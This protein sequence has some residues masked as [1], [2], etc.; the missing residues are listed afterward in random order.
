MSRKKNSNRE[1][2][3][4]DKTI[5]I[6]DVLMTSYLEREGRERE[7]ERESRTRRDNYIK[8]NYI[9]IDMFDSFT[10]DEMQKCLLKY[11]T[12]FIF[13]ALLSG[14]VYKAMQDGKAQTENMYYY[15]LI[16]TV[17]FF[18][19]YYYALLDKSMASVGM[20]FSIALIVVIISTVIYFYSSMSYESM[21]TVAYFLNILIFLIIMVALSAIAYIYANYLRSLRGWAG[22]LANFIFY[23]PCL[24]VDAV[25]FIRN[26]F[27]MTTNVVFIIFILEILL[28][29]LYIY[30]PTFIR[31]LIE[32]RSVA[33]LPDSAWLNRHQSFEIVKHA[34]NNYPEDTRNAKLEGDSGPVAL[35][36][37]VTLNPIYN[38]NFA[39]SMWVYLNDQ[40]ASH[41]GYNGERE[42]FSYKSINRDIKF[43]KP[44]VT[45]YNNVKN[46]KGTDKDNIIV[47]FTNNRNSGEN[48]DSIEPNTIFKTRIQ[49]QKW[50][51]FVFNYTS[52]YADFFINGNL[53]KTIPFTNN[54]PV[55]YDDDKITI[56][57]KNG[58]NGAICNIQYYKENLT[59]PQI[60]NSYNINMYNNPPT[61]N[62]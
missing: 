53:V 22:F 15:A 14:T 28:I 40:P 21:Q 17:S 57:Q 32:K 62:L 59:L 20:Y 4:E 41:T 9:I 8:G 27:K 55:F 29:L 33:I 49:K 38:Q 5:N 10:G 39:I 37:N 16:M 34:K 56:G 58:L 54:F 60:V 43:G 3:T 12:L 50:N 25:M 44:R 51:H 31:S 30:I 1:P 42:I 48:A 45:Y 13:I 36:P 52:S 6:H 18:F 11:G 46:G 35:N 19:V 7:R 2:L 24:V 47:Y 26:E 61:N 23:I